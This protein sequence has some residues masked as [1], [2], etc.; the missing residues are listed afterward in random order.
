VKALTLLAFGGVDQ[1]K[2]QEDVPDP[3]AGH[4]EVVIGSQPPA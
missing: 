4:D 1:F 3:V 2:F